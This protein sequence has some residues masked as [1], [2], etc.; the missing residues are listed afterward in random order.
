MIHL[1]DCG[2]GLPFGNGRN[3][4]DNDGDEEDAYFSTIT[5][6]VMLSAES[7]AAMLKW[8]NLLVMKAGRARGGDG[9]RL[10]PSLP[11]AAMMPMVARG[12]GL[13]GFSVP[14][15]GHALAHAHGYRNGRGR[16]CGADILNVLDSDLDALSVHEEGADLAESLMLAHIVSGGDGGG[17]GGDGDSDGEREGGM[18]VGPG[19]GLS[20]APPPPSLDALATPEE[21]AAFF[22]YGGW[23]SPIQA[24]RSDRVPTMGNELLAGLASAVDDADPA[25]AA[26]IAARAATDDVVGAGAGA[27]AGTDAQGLSALDA[28]AFSPP[29]HVHTSAT[30][31]VHTTPCATHAGVHARVNAL[32]IAAA[33]ASTH[34]DNADNEVSSY[35]HSAFASATTSR[36]SAATVTDDSAAYMDTDGDC[37]EGGGGIGELSLSSH[38]LDGGGGGGGH[39]DEGGD[40]DSVLLRIQSDAQAAANLFGDDEDADVDVDN[41]DYDMRVHMRLDHRQD[42]HSGLWT[43]DLAAVSSRSTEHS[44]F[45][46]PD[47]VEANELP[48]WPAGGGGCGHACSAGLQAHLS[49][50]SVPTLGSGGSSP[51]ISASD[52]I[53]VSATPSAASAPSAPSTPSAPSVSYV[54][55]VGP[56]PANPTTP[57]YRRSQSS[58]QSVRRGVSSCGSGTGSGRGAGRVPD[59]AP[60]EEVRE[61]TLAAQLSLGNE[62]LHKHE[63]EYEHGL[64]H[65]DQH[66][67]SSSRGQR[68]GVSMSVDGVPSAKATGPLHGSLHHTHHATPVSPIIGQWGDSE[69]IDALERELMDVSA[70]AGTRPGTGAGSYDSAT[71]RSAVREHDRHICGGNVLIRGRPP[72]V[73]AAVGAAVGAVVFKG[74]S[75]NGSDGGGGGDGNVDGGVGVG[76]VGIGDVPMEEALDALLVAAIGDGRESPGKSPPHKHRRLY[77]SPVTVTAAV[78]HTGGGKGGNTESMDVDADTTHVYKLGPVSPE[79]VAKER[80]HCHGTPREAAPV[81]QLPDEAH[82]APTSVAGTLAG[83]LVGASARRQPKPS[84]LSQM[85]LNLAQAPRGAF[86][87]PVL[88]N[89]HSHGHGHAQGHTQA[90]E[91]VLFTSPYDDDFAFPFTP[92]PFSSRPGSNRS[93]EC[94][95]DAGGCV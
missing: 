61:G 80:E 92:S 55:S 12:T 51:L 91:H 37:D 89:S 40:D 53:T 6:S 15:P 33:T 41:D 46:F 4:E 8:V 76:E 42:R 34:A 63:H 11:R 14:A 62:Y 69:L 86:C 36:Q 35:S 59:F 49:V 68:Q 10:Q 30:L 26:A 64:Q 70:C 71:S 88:T 57:V 72:A 95:V 13:G 94:H 74:G 1:Q 19:A 31:L 24:D 79:A 45:T 5:K 66:G 90:P 39:V 3:L 23:T 28:F 38:L 84:A 47:S 17:G 73:D 21:Q 2:M 18:S 25:H 22:G 54:P 48:F 67:R 52:C 16:R 7:H 82:V 60:I 93:S 43:T 27:S 77:T 87:S 78:H 81:L 83:G 58:V 65:Q 85:R 75:G 56:T 9:S 44:N 20:L 50:A 32:T 29:A